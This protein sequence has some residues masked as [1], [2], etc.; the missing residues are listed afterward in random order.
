LQVVRRGTTV[1]RDP[2]LPANVIRKLAHELVQKDPIILFAEPL[3]PRWFA[4][5]PAKRRQ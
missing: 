4:A 3:R 5:P 2:A 1:P